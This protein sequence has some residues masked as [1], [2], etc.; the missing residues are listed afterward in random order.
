M[1][2][3][4]PRRDRMKIPRLL[5]PLVVGAAALAFTATVTLATRA[6]AG[7][8]HLKIDLLV[9]NAN[10]GQPLSGKDPLTG[11]VL[12]QVAVR[13]N[14]V[15]CAGDFVVTALGA[16]GSPPSVLV[17]RVPFVIGPAVG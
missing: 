6:E 8:T 1:G 10:T 15:D 12:F 16:Q 14:G 4:E 7:R 11:P 3:N 2:L 9:T 13:T 5:L 17:Q